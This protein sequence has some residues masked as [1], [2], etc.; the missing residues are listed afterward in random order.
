MK[1]QYAVLTNGNRDVV[2]VISYTTHEELD[3]KTREQIKA[4]LVQEN[5]EEDGIELEMPKHPISTERTIQIF[6]KNTNRVPKV[7]FD[8]YWLTPVSVV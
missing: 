1:K 5:L 2:A 8:E 4:D 3:R 7:P 6:D